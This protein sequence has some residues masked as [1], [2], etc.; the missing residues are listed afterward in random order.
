MSQRFTSIDGQDL[1]QPLP[2]DPKTDIPTQIQSSVQTSLRNLRTTYLDSLVLHSPLRTLPQTLV[3][4][5]TL[6]SL[7]VSGVVRK[8]G[9]S[10]TYDIAMLEA[11]ERD[12]GCRPDVVQNRWFEGNQW[13]NAVW[14]YCVKHGIQYQCVPY[15]CP[16]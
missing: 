6:I 16:Y 3:A 9:V 10:N 5:R 1:T 8:I 12:G 2:Y 7:Q 14:A 15:S 11:L 13:D 4:W